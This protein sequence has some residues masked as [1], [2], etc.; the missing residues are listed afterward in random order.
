MHTGGPGF[1]GR[2]QF[3]LTTWGEAVH[4]IKNLQVMNLLQLGVVLS[5][6]KKQFKDE[7]L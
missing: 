6:S 5:E 2:N 3:Q 7:S 4:C 1:P